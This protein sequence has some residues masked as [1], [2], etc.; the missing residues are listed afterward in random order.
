ME[1]TV[2]MVHALP[3]D[4]NRYEVIDGELFVNPAP[5][6]GHQRAL[7]VMYLLLAPYAESV[8]LELLFAPVAI[9]F[10]PRT[11]VQPDLVA[12][13]RLDDGSV[14]DFREA[15]QLTLAVE[16]LSPTTARADR[17]KKRQLFQKYRVAEYWIVDAAN[18]LIE[19]WRPQ[20]AEPDVVLQAMSWQ[21]VDDFEPL[22]ID[23]AAY[24]RKVYGER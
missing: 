4:G 24:F 20:D 8:G 2:E 22:Q 7:G 14:P 13:P 18:R 15:G 9:L 1:W 16:A 5:S 17:H 21:P 23:V 10:S 3:D 6:V 12:W 19:R 11:E